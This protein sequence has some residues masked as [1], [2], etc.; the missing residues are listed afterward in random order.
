MSSLNIFGF[1]AKMLP[2]VSKSD[3]EVDM[4]ISLEAASTVIDVYTQ[5]AQVHQNTKF[6]SKGALKLVAEFQ[7]ELTQSKPEVK[8]S[9]H[10][11]L[12]ATTLVLFKNV[13]ANGEVITKELEDIKSEVIVSQAITSSKATILRAVAHYYFMTKFALD[14]ANYLVLLEAQ[15][16]G[17]EMPRDAMLNKKQSD[18]I[19][20]NLWIY[21]RLLAV[22]GSDTDKFLSRLSG[23]E[24]FQITKDSV[25]DSS[26]M[27]SSKIDLFNNLPVG[28]IG[29][30][31]YTV[32]LIF[33]QWEADRHKELK[34]KKRLLELRLLHL[35]VLQEQ[36]KGDASSEK[37]ITYL[38]KRV[39]D[40]DYK[41]FKIESELND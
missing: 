30:P 36:G 12:A 33:A 10:N 8:L 3:S 39:T 41:V 17:V 15:H 9:G 24:K 26:T 16:G 29:S 6:N 23:I 28:F 35:R 37:E 11:G 34:D 20:K 18:Y 31:I 2:S 5:L 19:E 4:E 13:L 21:A 1:V 32:G 38:Q 40:I 25:D 22:Y 14:F 27:S 7:K